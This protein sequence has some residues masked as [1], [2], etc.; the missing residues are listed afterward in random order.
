M[1]K[2]VLTALCVFFIFTLCGC[3]STG[4]PAVTDFSADFAANYMDMELKGRLSADR[5]G[6]L[7]VELTSPDDLSGV[8]IAY[9]NGEAE[10]KRD[11]LI[12]TA[13]EAYLPDGSFTS[14]IKSAL[15]PVNSDPE[16]F[17]SGRHELES[18][19]RSFA[20]DID[21]EGR[22]TGIAS[23]GEFEIEFKNIKGSG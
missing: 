4:R 6:L 21:E 10:L 20:I 3:G 19:G 12:C 8:M 18:G 16:G 14:L 1:A 5:R 13:D 17:G 22:I 9:K 23:P 11:G 2:R 15:L 7:S